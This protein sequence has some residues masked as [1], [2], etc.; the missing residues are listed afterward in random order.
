MSSSVK[1]LLR[2]RPTAFDISHGNDN[3]VVAAPEGLLF[4]H[5]NGLG[6][7]HH[8]I[9]Y[10]QA[11]VVS[12]LRFHRQSGSSESHDSLA[13]LRGGVVSLWNPSNSL[14]PLTSFLQPPSS[15]NAFV[16]DMEWSLANSSLLA[17]CG[18]GNG[19]SVAHIW[20][21]RSNSSLPVNTILTAEGRTPSNLYES[22]SGVEYH[23]LDWCESDA[24]TNNLL[25][26][27]T[28]SNV[29]LFDLRKLG[30]PHHNQVHNTPLLGIDSVG[31]SGAI[32]HCSWCGAS[33]SFVV[34]SCYTDTI[35]WWSASSL[36]IEIKQHANNLLHRSSQMLSTPVGKALILS[37]PAY[38]SNP[39]DATP[40]QPAGDGSD[41]PNP[42]AAASKLSTDGSKSLATTLML[43]GYPRSF[44]MGSI[45]TPPEA[46][47]EE[48]PFM[49][50]TRFANNS[51]QASHSQ[52]GPSQQLNVRS[53]AGA[54]PYARQQFA[55]PY[56]SNIGSRIISSNHQVSN[57]PPALPAEQAGEAVE[58]T[59]P[60]LYNGGILGMKWGTPGRLIPPTHGGL[61]LLVF[62]DNGL[63]QAIKI[64]PEVTSKYTMS[65]SVGKDDSELKRDVFSAPTLTSP[66]R[67]TAGS[68]VGGGVGGASE[69]SAGATAVHPTISAHP[70]TNRR[71]VPPPQFSITHPLTTSNTGTSA[72]PAAK[73]SFGLPQTSH[74]FPTE[75][76]TSHDFWGSV[77]DEVLCLQDN[78]GNFLV[79]LQNVAW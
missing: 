9:N 61:E 6:A 51:N 63:L 64:T 74:L 71:H 36:S 38:L 41:L 76:T 22:S 4:F 53:S 46:G 19:G 39:S 75:T 15:S 14:R 68:A 67:T 54:H 73:P 31:D 62:T 17:T 32:S 5:V 65:R 20:D 69:E 35:E 72:P 58:E 23:S 56:G 1:L 44:S 10:E 42:P 34:G 78:L 2:N 57:Q 59:V 33:S 60:G 29:S 27:K 77:E 7:P 47:Y 26:L 70:R 37:Q 30:K 43:S 3:I 45:F 16:V 25:M 55:D 18:S 66:V 49:L 28:P 40:P 12:Q 79:L 13:A 21:I 24:S 8:I 52:F 48:S 50:L 11:Q